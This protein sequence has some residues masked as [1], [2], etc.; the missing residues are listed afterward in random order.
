MI[1]RTLTNINPMATIPLVGQTEAGSAEVQ[2][3]RDNQPKAT[4]RR[5]GGSNTSAIPL[6]QQKPF[7]A[8][9]CL[10]KPL[11]KGKKCL[12]SVKWI[13]PF[14]AEPIQSSTQALT[15]TTLRYELLMIAEQDFGAA[16]EHSSELRRGMNLYQ[17]RG[18]YRNVAESLGIEYSPLETVLEL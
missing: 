2:P 13:C 5:W 8:L 9:L 14:H 15:G 4:N 10:K 1:K 17:G 12:L 6:Y 16:C 18:V 3:T 11:A 7:R